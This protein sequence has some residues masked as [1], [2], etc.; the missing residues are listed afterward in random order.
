MRRWL[1]IDQILKEAVTAILGVALVAATITLAVWTA[2]LAGDTR[3]QDMKDVLQVMVGLAGVVLGYYFGRIPAD[4]RAAQAQDRMETTARRA[5]EVSA[6]GDELADCVDDM[7][8]V[9]G[10]ATEADME[11]MRQLRA[12]LRA[13]T[14]AM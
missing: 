3:M 13:L 5:G 11:R 6:K 14:Q 10:Q 4:A 9:L 8:G 2:F 12:E 1:L 7:V